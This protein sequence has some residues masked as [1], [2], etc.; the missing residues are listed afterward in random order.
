[1]SFAEELRTLFPKDVIDCIKEK[2]RTAASIGETD[3]D[4]LFDSIYGYKFNKQNFGVNGRFINELKTWA[5][6][7]VIELKL[8]EK[9]VGWNF[10]WKKT[11]NKN[12]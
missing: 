7:N 9:N 3:L 5:T 2:L 8:L 11:E 10:S 6:N 4:V 12:D 1:M